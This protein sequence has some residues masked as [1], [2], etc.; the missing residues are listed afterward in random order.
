M[1]TTYNIYT[2]HIY[3][4][5]SHLTWMGRGKYEQG[6]RTVLY[7][8]SFRSN[9]LAPQWSRFPKNK[10]NKKYLI[11]AVLVSGIHGYIQ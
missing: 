5:L 7:L 10:R 8:Y 4:L 9:T 3:E 6:V 11:V 2:R 1:Y